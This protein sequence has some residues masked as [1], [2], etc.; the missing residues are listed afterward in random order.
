MVLFIVVPVAFII[1]RCH[2][3]HQFIRADSHRKEALVGSNSSTVSDTDK[4]L[5]IPRALDG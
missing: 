4:E 3:C 2:P 1:V 5:F